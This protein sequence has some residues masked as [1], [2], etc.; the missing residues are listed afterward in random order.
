MN[1]IISHAT[2]DA[3]I[4]ACFPIFAL[5]RPH[6]KQENFLAQ[7]RRQELQGYRITTLHRVSPALPPLGSK[8]F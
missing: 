3:E 7:V 6:L 1:N 8:P 4:E 5:L 2:T